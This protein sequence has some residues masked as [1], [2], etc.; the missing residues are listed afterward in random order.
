M[1]AHLALYLFSAL[2]VSAVA[3]VAYAA[4]NSKTFKDTS[5]ILPAGDAAEVAYYADQD[6]APKDDQLMTWLSAGGAGFILLIFGLKRAFSGKNPLDQT[7]KKIGESIAAQERI[8]KSIGQTLDE[9]KKA[10]I[11]VDTVKR[12]F[13]AK[14]E[15][16]V[17]KNVAD[18]DAIEAKITALQKEHGEDYD[19]AAHHPELKEEWD[20]AMKANDENHSSVEAA[21]NEADIE[22]EG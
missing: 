10:T 9:A 6:T 13:V 12:E 14:M 19:W 15:A 3:Y 1:I 17:A 18:L 22:F 11:A 8:E 20:E 4:R 16:K 5:S 2:W 21:F 7:N